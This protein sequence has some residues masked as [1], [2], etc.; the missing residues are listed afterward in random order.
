MVDT[1]GELSDIKIVRGPGELR[2][3]VLNVLHKS[4]NWIPAFMV[5]GRKFKS[6]KM[7][8]IYFRLAHAQ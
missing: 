7:Q 6:Y 5:N 3:A 4:P 8:A 1:A 2:Q